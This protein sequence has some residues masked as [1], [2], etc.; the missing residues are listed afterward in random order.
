MSPYMS[1]REAEAYSIS[2]IPDFRASVGDVQANTPTIIESPSIIR[3]LQQINDTLLA[4]EKRQNDQQKIL[5]ALT[6]TPI[7]NLGV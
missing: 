1:S 2:W 5:D 7:Q 6:N 3:G 4:I